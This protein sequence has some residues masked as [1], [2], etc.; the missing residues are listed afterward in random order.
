MAV[1]N[2]LDKIPLMMS[3][4]LQLSLAFK[5]L[6]YIDRSIS[7]L[8]ED[9]YFYWEAQ[10][11]LAFF[12]E[13][14]ARAIQYYEKANKLF[15]SLQD[16]HQWFR[17]NLNGLFYVLALLYQTTTSEELKKAAAAIASMRKIQVHEAIP[18]I[19]EAILN[20]KCNDRKIAITFYNNAKRNIGDT[21]SLLPI[22]NALIDWTEAL[23][24]PEQLPQLTQKYR[25]RFRHY[26]DSS[27]NFTAQIYAELIELQNE[28]DE[29]TQYFF[30][31]FSPFGNFRFMNIL[32]VKQPWEYAIDQLHNILTD[33]AS[34]NQQAVADR[35]MIWLV[36]PKSLQIEV[37][38]QSLRKNRTWSPGR[39]IAL[40]RIYAMDSN[41]DYLTAYDQ[42]AISGLRREVYGWH[43]HELFSWDTRQT[44]TALIGHPS[45]FH[46]QNRDIP[47][48][49]IKGTVELQV[50]KTHSGYHFSLSKFSTTPR[51]FLEK[52]S[53]N[54][55]RVI[56]LSD[57]MVSICKI[58]T[59]KGMTVP[60]QAKDK[61]IS[62]I[63]N[64]KSTIHIQSDVADEDLPTLAGNTTPCVHLFPIQDGLKVNLWIRPL[65]EQGSYY[66]ASHGQQS[67]ITSITTSQGEE[68]KKV[69]R[70]FEKEKG[71][72]DS[73]INQCRTLV[74]FDEMTDEW[75]VPT[76]EESL[77]L[78][79]ELEEYKKN[80]P[81]TI[82]WP[83]GQTLKVKK[84][85]S[86]K[87]LSLTIKG[88]E[89][90]FE[91]DGEVNIDE[92]HALDIKK[93]LDLLGQA[94]GRF[95]PL[96]SGE[97]IALTE[98]FR[99]QLEDLRA[100]SDGNK[101]YHLSSSGLRGLAEEAGTLKEDQ[102]WTTH[103]KKLTAM[104]KHQPMIPS[105]LQAELRD[106]QKEGFSYLSRLAHWEIGLA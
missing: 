73:L 19:L 85:V 89:Y 66:R 93:L 62:M 99:K 1:K 64:A 54:R 27:Q 101:I 33:K 55:Y 76:L 41:L 35:R 16:K 26:H 63:C 20:L 14:K 53:T 9:Q 81:L 31:S 75:Y 43:K 2:N 67:I 12:N 82:E 8:S 25:E 70:D 71:N 4:L 28:T 94:Q 30:K 32:R 79:L 44:L 106:Y 48:E 52:E 78:M 10:G 97:F 21:T 74:E 13:N 91:Y 92:G 102:A 46:S 77:E 7:P 50:E 59:E 29:E 17:A 69:I 86:S 6:S 88:S 96:A 98:K 84:T 90:W 42:T 100:L 40:K 72:I 60:F 58:L 61:V 38:E 34:S 23:L 24:E 56:E 57:E 11:A 49:L 47:M 80:H 15:K 95:I 5:T 103:I 83:K 18:D 3:R 87:N 37:A 105:T 51:V 104:E 45:V 68:R 39:P 22:L 65:G 36:D